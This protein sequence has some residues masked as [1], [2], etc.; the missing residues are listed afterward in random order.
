LAS[1]F[2]HGQWERKGTIIVLKSNNIDSC[3]YLTYFGEDCIVLD[4]LGNT[5]FVIEKT[6]ND[7]EPEYE[8]DYVVFNNEEFYLDN[9]TMKHILKKAKLCLEIRNDFTKE[10]R[11]ITSN[12]Y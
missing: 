6:I 9:D 5:D 8:T 7:C 12:K 2:S 10:I 4:S 11:D 3:L 1:D